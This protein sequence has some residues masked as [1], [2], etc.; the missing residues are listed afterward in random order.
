MTDTS[1]DE[2]SSRRHV[3]RLIGGAGLGLVAA[4]CSV[5]GADDASTVSTNTP[6]T[7]APPPPVRPTSVVLDDPRGD[8]PARTRATARTG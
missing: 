7:T 2:I 3:L 6:S 1:N 5:K 4:A 8:R